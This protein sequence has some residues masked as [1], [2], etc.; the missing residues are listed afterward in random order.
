[1]NG[2]TGRGMRRGRNGHCRGGNV[3]GEKK[4]RSTATT[5]REERETRDRKRGKD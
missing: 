3:E 5:D 4:E 2:L 1:M